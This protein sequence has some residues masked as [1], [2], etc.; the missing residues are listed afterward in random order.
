MPA[1]TFDEITVTRWISSTPI[2]P[3]HSRQVSFSIVAS[4]AA[5]RGRSHRSL[6]YYS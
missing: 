3:R 2:R 6:S 4:L 5:E 1:W